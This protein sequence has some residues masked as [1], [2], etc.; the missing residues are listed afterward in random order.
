M[1][2]KPG[3]RAVP[4][5]A[6]G[7]LSSARSDEHGLVQLHPG[8]STGRELL[9]RLRLHAQLVPG[10]HATTQTIQTYLSLPCKTAHE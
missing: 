4:E 5:D 7:T 10:T 2:G 9:R 3:P 8:I 6:G 1:Q